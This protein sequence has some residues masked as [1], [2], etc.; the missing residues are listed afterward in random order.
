MTTAPGG[1]SWPGTETG[2]IL[3]A[4]VRSSGPVEPVAPGIRTGGWSHRPN[5]T[6][7][8]R[9]PAGLSHRVWSFRTRTTSRAAQQLPSCSRPDGGPE[10]G[11]G[12]S[13]GAVQL[14]TVH[15]RYVS[16]PRRLPVRRAPLAAL[17]PPRG[18]GETVRGPRGRTGPPGGLGR[19]R[20]TAPG[21]TSSSCWTSTGICC[22][23]PRACGDGTAPGTGAATTSPSPRCSRARMA[24][25]SSLPTRT[26]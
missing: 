2:P 7:P 23:T 17:A 22:G 21:S 5:L 16:A 14:P 1:S 13:D 9:Y 12:D 11:R 19:S 15:P 26:A 8:D 4:S 18:R 3:T 25:H 20:S 24:R 6:V 10:Q